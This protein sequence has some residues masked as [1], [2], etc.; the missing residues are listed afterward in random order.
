MLTQ[1]A[2]GAVTF[3]DPQWK[4]TGTNLYPNLL[5]SDV[6]IGTATPNQ[7]LD[8]ATGGIRAGGFGAFTGVAATSQGAHLQWNRSG[9]EGE[10]WLIN[11]L[12]LG[13]ANAGIRF[14][15]ITT[16]TGTA[17]TEWARFL[18][19][20]NFGIGTTAPTAK[21]QVVAP[22]NS[23]NTYADFQPLNLT[24]GVGVWYGGLRKTGSNAASDFSID[25]K[26]TGNIVLNANGGT[27]NVGIGT[28]APGTKLDVAGVVRGTTFTF[29]DLF[30]G[31]DPAGV[32]T[33]RAVPTGQGA[34]GNPGSEIAE[35]IIF[36][37]NDGTACCGPDRI[38]LRAPLI[39]LQ[40]FNNGV[41]TINDDAGSID[42]LTIDPNGM[43]GVNSLAG[44]G[45][46][47]VT[48]DAAGNLSSASTAAALDATTASNGLTGVGADV[49]LGGSLTQAT[50]IAQ[51]GNAFSL[52]GGNVGIGTA[53]PSQKLDVRGNIRLGDDG[54]TAA[55]GTGN[56]IEFVGPGVNTDVVGFYRTNPASNA[57]ELR[58]VVG[59]DPTS[60]VD[61]LVVG[62]TNTFTGPDQLTTGAFTPQFTVLSSGAVV[63]SILSAP[64]PTS[65]SGFA[66]VAGI[67]RF[68]DNG[69]ATNGTIALATGGQMME[70]QTVMISN[71]D[72]QAITISCAA[73][74]VTLN[75]YNTARFVYIGGLW[76]RGI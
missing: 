35:T 2:S 18:N 54:G 62:T 16:S 60:Y 22:D 48:A 61:R 9:S 23:T 6:G 38:T 17:P 15:G 33:S 67:Y 31:G 68:T 51:G 66:P 12:G 30:G 25:G 7:K 20:G 57:S 36:Q 53:T 49:R 59:D 58:A 76:T 64:V 29:P 41:G 32:I 74:N 44:T 14:G 19:N 40:T 42:R 34:P 27:G 43:V 37:A 56:A 69:S 52:T 75:Q 45:T 11:H 28:T 26:T 63:Q 47:M 4:Q 71:F 5:N 1:Q 72:T 3:A 50:T 13:G 73:G 24:Q 10:T 65:A 21:L 8:V 70:G 55:T 39:R 46:R